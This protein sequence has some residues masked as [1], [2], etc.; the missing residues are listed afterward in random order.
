[1]GGI[2]FA[3]SFALEKLTLRTGIN[4]ANVSSSSMLVSLWYHLELG[5]TRHV[6]GEVELLYRPVLG[7]TG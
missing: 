7:G 3:M 6:R 5:W 4:S 2:V 1:M